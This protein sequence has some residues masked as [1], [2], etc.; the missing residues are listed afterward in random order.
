[1]G[2]SSVSRPSGLWTHR[3]MTPVFLHL[4]NCFSRCCTNSREL[5]RHR[6]SLTMK[7]WSPGVNSSS[8]LSSLKML[9]ALR[10]LIAWIV[11]GNSSWLASMRRPRSQPTR[12]GISTVQPLA[13][14]NSVFRC[15]RR[16]APCPVNIRLRRLFPK[17][18]LSLCQSTLSALRIRS[19]T[20]RLCVG[21]LSFQVL[22]KPPLGISVMLMGSEVFIW[23]TQPISV[24]P[25]KSDTLASNV[26]SND[27]LSST[28]A[29]DLGLWMCKDMATV[30]FASAIVL[31]IIVSM[32]FLKTFVLWCHWMPLDMTISSP[33]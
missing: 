25:L 10:G 8:G 19:P 29:T 1:M 3:R 33:G 24:D 23:R 14:L 32:R 13:Y 9:T 28:S 20:A 11:T 4:E 2:S 30:E 7:I 27:L 15:T 21:F 22:R 16:V 26:S 5:L 6:K 17:L 12:A 31:R 18:P